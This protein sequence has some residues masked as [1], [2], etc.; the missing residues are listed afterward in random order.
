MASVS[1]ASSVTL[2]LTWVF[3]SFA[4]GRDVCAFLLL[5][6]G[7]SLPC[8]LPRSTTVGQLKTHA[9]EHWHLLPSS[10]KLVTGLRSASE[11]KSRSTVPSDD[12]PLSECR[13]AASIM[14]VAT[15]LEDAKPQQPQTQNPSAALGQ[16][17]SQDD[18]DDAEDEQ[19][20]EQYILPQK[21]QELDREQQQLRIGNAQREAQY[22]RTEQVPESRPE[23]PWPAYLQE[24][25]FLGRHEELARIYRRFPDSNASMDRVIR[26]ACCAVRNNKKE[27]L[28]TCLSQVRAGHGGIM[29][30]ILRPVFRDAFSFN[31]LNLLSILHQHVVHCGPVSQ[32][33]TS[34]PMDTRSDDDAGSITTAQETKAIATDIAPD[35]NDDGKSH[36]L[37]WL[38]NVKDAYRRF[39]FGTGDQWLDH[40]AVYI[41]CDDWSL[42][43]GKWIWEHAGRPPLS[44]SHLIWL[45]RSGTRKRLGAVRFFAQYTKRDGV[46]SLEETSGVNTFFWKR[47]ELWKAILLHVPNRQAHLDAVLCTLK[48]T[49]EQWQDSAKDFPVDAWDDLCLIQGANVRQH[50]DA[51]LVNSFAVGSHHVTHT[52][53]TA[54][55]RRME[56]E[57]RRMNEPLTDRRALLSVFSVGLSPFC[58]DEDHLC[59]SAESYDSTQIDSIHLCFRH[60][61]LA[62]KQTERNALLRLLLVEWQ[63]FAVISFDRLSELYCVQDVHFHS[64]DDRGV[65]WLKLHAAVQHSVGIESFALACRKLMPDVLNDQVCG[66]VLGY[67]LDFGVTGHLLNRSLAIAQWLK[68]EQERQDKRHRRSRQTSEISV[69]L[70]DSDMQDVDEQGI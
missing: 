15:A 55:I 20:W 8:H 70:D 19:E 45:A 68:E 6:K 39:L 65:M 11:T 13:I 33:D 16:N 41:H 50:R 40:N 24:L 57:A 21:K 42:A 69:V 37:G 62:R 17:K 5:Q 38:R 36:V 66:I 35:E 26:P 25:A 60:A 53:W 3:S 54:I 49:V 51:C 48:P 27:A 64:D 28:L 34:T 18:Q 1:D 47:H 61:L 44:S 63:W 23:N 9:C 56:T 29:L 52:V 7:Q 46:D 59:L 43:V 67:F 22:R 14:V 12:T 10:C 30:D 2:A 31:R 4:T 32:D 58:A